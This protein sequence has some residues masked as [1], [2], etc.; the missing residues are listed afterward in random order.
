MQV[1]L[2]DYLITF[3]W[4]VT[5]LIILSVALP[6]LVWV[7]NKIISDID[8]D[9]ELKKGNIAVAILLAAVVIGVCLV[10]GLVV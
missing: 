5:I 1:I 7:F 4:I 10:V 9:K 6:G 2:N 3:G 8:V